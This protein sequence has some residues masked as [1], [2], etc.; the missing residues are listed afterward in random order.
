ME[1][2]GALRDRVGQM[3]RADVL[4]GIDR[5]LGFLRH[6][7][8]P[9]AR[10]EELVLYPEVARVL[11][12]HLS[13]TLVR[14]HREVERL[15]TVLDAE[16]A[17]VAGGADVP[18]SLHA[19]LTSVVGVLRSHLRQE[20]EVL[21]TLLDEHLSDEEA[22]DLYERMEEATFDAVVALQGTRA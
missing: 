21:L 6:D 7:V 2:I 17:V 18:P 11:N 16:R 19:T 15:V 13:Q 1:A 4:A 10:A 20:E 14:E 3:E 12:V 5:A 8:A 9:H 22:Y